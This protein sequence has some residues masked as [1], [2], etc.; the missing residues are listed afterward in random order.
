MRPGSLSTSPYLA[1]KK[2]MSSQPV[3]VPTPQAVAKHFR[4]LA[5]HARRSRI[6]NGLL[7]IGVGNS[8]HLR[9]HILPL[10]MQKGKEIEGRC[11]KVLPESGVSQHL[12]PV[13][14]NYIK[15]VKT[16]PRDLAR[17]QVLACMN[18]SR[19]CWETR[20]LKTHELLQ[21]ISL[22][23]H[24]AECPNCKHTKQFS[25]DLVSV[26]VSPAREAAKKARATPLHSTALCS[27]LQWQLRQV[28]A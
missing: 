10:Q 23:Y 20:L 21:L 28:A 26:P 22:Y 4:L 11:A 8:W 9:L 14:S 15:L 12:N 1:S 13:W 18:L 2:R 5:L 19:R 17:F 24:G 7:I 6:H 25:M 3:R 27:A 16:D